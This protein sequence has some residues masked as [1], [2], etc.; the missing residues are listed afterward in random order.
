MYVK[1]LLF[2]IILILVM[3]NVA[4]CEGKT[5]EKF[6]SLD[7][8]PGVKELTDIRDEVKTL[9]NQYL[10][11]ISNIENILNEIKDTNNTLLEKQLDVQYKSLGESI[12]TD[13]PMI[14]LESFKVRLCG[15][16]EDDRM[17]S[18]SPLSHESGDSSMLLNK[19]IQYKEDYNKDNSRSCSLNKKE[20]IEKVIGKLKKM[21]DQMDTAL[22]PCP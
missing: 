7:S 2:M 17:V 20:E 19:Y 22:Y 14:S 18:S 21:L 9:N 12:L 6:I 10:G 15:E 5:Y 3:Y 4:W 11:K 8:L 13:D 1:Y 16:K